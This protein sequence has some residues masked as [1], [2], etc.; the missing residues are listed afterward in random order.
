MAQYVNKLSYFVEVQRSN[1]V[2]VVVLRWKDIL[3]TVVK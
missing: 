1:K 2:V 3:V